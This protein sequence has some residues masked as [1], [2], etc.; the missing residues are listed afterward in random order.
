MSKF[1][2]EVALHGGAVLGVTIHARDHTGGDFLREN[3]APVDGTVACGAALARA[4]MDRMAEENVVRHL[5]HA[6]GP[7]ARR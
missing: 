2:A 3:L 6:R 5:V 1:V 4:D 7:N